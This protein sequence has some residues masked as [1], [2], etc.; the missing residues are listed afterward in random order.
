MAELIDSQ[1]HLDNQSGVN[2]ITTTLPLID[3]EL[4]SQQPVNN[5]GVVSAAR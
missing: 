4:Y 3:N 2:A 5:S 1:M